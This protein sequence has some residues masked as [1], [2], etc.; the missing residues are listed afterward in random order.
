MERTILNVALLKM[1]VKI[2]NTRYTHSHHMKTGI[3][4]KYFSAAKV[5][6]VCGNHFTVGSTK[7]HIEVEICYKCHPFYTGKEKLID[8]A[9]KVEKFRARREKAAASAKNKE[10][11]VRP[12][13]PQGV[14]APTASVGE[15]RARK[16]TK[17]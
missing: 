8:T 14:G 9:G 6:C 12:R 16:Q 13:R 4:P 5:K 3:H 15:V 10:K 17:K 11:K 1:L 7:E 2:I